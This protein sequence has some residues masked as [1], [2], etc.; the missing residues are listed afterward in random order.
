MPENRNARAMVRSLWAA[1]AVVSI[2][3]IV[4]GIVIF[5]QWRENLGIIQQRSTLI[6]AALI[7]LVLLM[8]NSLKTAAAAWIASADIETGENGIHLY[9]R[10]DNPITIG[11]D[12]TKGTEIRKVDMPVM[13]PLKMGTVAY[14]VQ[15]PTL[16]FL[17]RLTGLEF[18]QGLKPVFVVTTAHD[19]YE[20]LLDQL[21]DGWATSD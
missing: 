2:G 16:G 19:H 13:F 3:F 5:A 14:T 18:G 11:W 10:S 1:N 6:L 7:V 15:V 17:F 9:V 20:R 12:A 8:L 4:L 21:R